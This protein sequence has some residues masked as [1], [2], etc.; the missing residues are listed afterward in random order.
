MSM[1]LLGWLYP[2]LPLFSSPP[3]SNTILRESVPEWDAAQHVPRDPPF[4]PWHCSPAAEEAGHW[5]PRALWLHGST[6]CASIRG[7]QV[8]IKLR[9][10]NYQATYSS[11]TPPHSSSRDL[12][13]SSGAPQL[14]GCPGRWRGADRA[15]IH[16]GWVSFGSPTGQDGHC[17][18]R[19]Q[20]F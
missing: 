9:N 19:L 13:A 12:N 20:L 4:Q 1:L 11:R 17:K 7:I 18:H 8:G 16:D 14:P 15:G 10:W 2:Y 5:W 6:R 3:S